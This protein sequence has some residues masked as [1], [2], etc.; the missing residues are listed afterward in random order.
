MEFPVKT[1]PHIPKGSRRAWL[2]ERSLPTCY[3]LDI[4][5]PELKIGVEID[6]ISHTGKRRKLDQKKNAHLKS[7][8]WQV[9]RLSN[10]QVEADLAGCVRTVMSTI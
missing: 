8:G 2:G 3:K 4:A 6:G 7:L 10:K 5:N 9:L 1:A